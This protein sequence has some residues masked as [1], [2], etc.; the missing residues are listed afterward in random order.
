MPFFAASGRL[1]EAVVVLFTI[2]I[3][4]ASFSSADSALTSMTTSYCIDISGK[5]DDE[6][7]RKFVHVV[8][9]A[10]FAVIIFIVEA[11]GSTSVIDAIYTICSYT[12]GPLLGLFAFA[13][14]CGDGSGYGKTKKQLSGRVVG[15]IAIMSPLLCYCLDMMTSTLWNYHFGYELLMLNGMMTFV[16]MYV[17][18]ECGMLNEES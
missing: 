9:A 3:V 5:P 8:M 13:Y 6:R 7:L 11:I 2:G 15:T 16:A 14:F 4:A 18:R 1:G 12:Y 10:I 17:A